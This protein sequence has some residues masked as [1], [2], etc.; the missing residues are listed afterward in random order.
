MDLDAL[1]ALFSSPQVR[2][3]DLT[4]PMSPDMPVWPTHPRFTQ[5]LVESYERGD[6]ACNHALCM[7]E[8]SGTHF[9]AP[10]HFVRGG[11]AIDQIEPQRFFGRMATINCRNVAPRQAVGIE[12][13]LDFE[14][15]H[16]AIRPGD[17]VFFHFG[18]DAHWTEPAPHAAFLADW[19]GLSEAAADWLVARQVRIAGSDCLSL[20]AFGSTAFPA[21]RRLLGAGVLIG[22]NFARLGELPPFAFLITLPLPI[23]A[24]SGAP[25]R[26][27]AVVGAATS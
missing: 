21:H 16:G 14:A 23:R 26:A 11:A 13:I 27:I 7:S 15:R 6:V 20:D 8:H 5:E 4:H 10:L 17:A 19:P 18:W 12:T 25:L 3:V 1:S 9:D 22:E 2:L 24:G